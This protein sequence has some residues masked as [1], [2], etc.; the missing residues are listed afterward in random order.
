MAPSCSTNFGMGNAMIRKTRGPRTTSQTSLWVIAACLLFLFMVSC[1]PDPRQRLAITVAS[2]DDPEQL[3]LGKATV[4]ALE[5]AGYKVT[6]KTGLGAPWVVRKA[7]EAGNVDVCW[8]YTGTVWSKYLHHD[9]PILNGE[10]LFQKVRQEDLLNGITWI[11]TARRQ[12]HVTILVRKS[13]AQQRGLLT[14]EDLAHYIKRENPEVSLCTT[15]ESYRSAK[16]VHGVEVIY[17]FHFEEKQLRLVSSEE[18]ALAALQQDH[19]ECALGIRPND[20]RGIDLLPLRDTRGFFPPSQLAVAVRTATLR[21]LPGIEYPLRKLGTLLTDKALD[22]L[23]YQVLVEEKPPERVAKRFIQ[24]SGIQW[25]SR[26][27]R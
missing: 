11:S 25:D 21:E 23:L 9:Q 6:D 19:C 8:D 22:E 7:F 13:W 5:A 20:A 10:E 17:G 1:Q 24:D 12:R 16:G 3:I 4:Y 14:I 18:E 15:E 26:Q 2:G 27:V